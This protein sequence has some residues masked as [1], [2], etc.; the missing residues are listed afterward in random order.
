MVFGQE[1]I[2]LW[3]TVSAGKHDQLNCET[4]FSVPTRNYYP[5]SVIYSKDLCK[6]K[7]MLCI[8]LR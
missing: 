6:Q 2:P 1:N 8:D 4:L 5:K 7:E 3:F